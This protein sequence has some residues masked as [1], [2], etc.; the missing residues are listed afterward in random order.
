MEQGEG[1]GFF[2]GESVFVNT[3]FDI[4]GTVYSVNNTV[5]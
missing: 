1:E 2:R 5:D 4:G 3:S